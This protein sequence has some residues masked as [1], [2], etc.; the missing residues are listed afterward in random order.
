MASVADA[1]C[2]RDRLNVQY[3]SVTARSGH[4]MGIRWIRTL[5]GGFLIE[6]VLA[7]VLIGGFALA[8]VDLANNISTRS[9]VVIGIGCF[10]GAFAVVVALTRRMPRPTL[11]GFLMGVVATVIYVGLILAAGQMPAALAAYGATT[12]VIVNG[13]RIVGAVAGGMMCERSQRVPEVL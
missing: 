9:A 8:G 7:V 6:V 11:H 5:L 12:F 4:I 2:W 3:G 13:L 1:A 10:T